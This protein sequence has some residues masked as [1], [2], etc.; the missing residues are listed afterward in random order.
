MGSARQGLQWAA[1]H[2]LLALHVRILRM[3]LCRLLDTCSR[4]SQ[5]SLL[6][7]ALR[8]DGSPPSDHASAAKTLAHLYIQYTQPWNPVSSNITSLPTHALVPPAA[9]GCSALAC[10]VEQAQLFSMQSHLERCA[11]TSPRHHL[12]TEG[13]IPTC[14]DDNPNFRVVPGISEAQRH[15]VGCRA[16]SRASARWPAVWGFSVTGRAAHL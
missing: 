14:Q 10:S 9:E 2:L 1:G 7:A 4:S 3:S 16:H 12:H 11:A 8:R 15:L 13:F 5:E 6:T